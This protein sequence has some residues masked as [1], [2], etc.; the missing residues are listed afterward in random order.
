[1]SDASGYIHG[2]TDEEAQRLIDQAEFLAPFV[3]DG[4]ELDG[5]GTLLEVGMGVGA[6]TRLLRR[7]WPQLRVVGCDI[8]DGQLAHARRIL[9]AD[10][11]AGAVELIRASATAVPL[12]DD[13]ADA[14]FVCWLLEHVSDPAAVLRECARVVEPGGRIFVTEVYNHSLTVEPAQPILDRFWAAINSTQRLGGGHP[15]IGA[16]LGELAA[17]AGLEIVSHRF[18]PVLGDAR[19]PAGRT[20]KLRYFRTLMMS[21]VPQVRAAHMF[22]E[23]DLASVWTAWDAAEAAPDALFCYTMCK[24]EARVAR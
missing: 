4:V 22:D 8:S 3:F 18:V 13:S 21:A 1:M 10:V 9:A 5:V 16:R 17:G 12:P 19:D 23:R 14:G 2:Y 20:A 7:R 24:L 11:A 15:N 6:E